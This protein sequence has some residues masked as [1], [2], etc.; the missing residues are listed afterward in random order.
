MRDFVA[1]YRAK[2]AEAEEKARRAT[3]PED[4]ERYLQTAREWTQIAEQA[5]RPGGAVT[6]PDD[7]NGN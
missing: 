1:Y 7:A 2:A 6:R 5:E 3:H 4:R